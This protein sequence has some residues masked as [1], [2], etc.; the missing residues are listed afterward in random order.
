VSSISQAFTHL[1]LILL[2][3][4][5]RAAVDDPV[6]MRFNNDSGSNYDSQFL[7]SFGSSTNAAH[8]N[9]GTVFQ[10]AGYTTG[11]TGAANK[12]GIIE[13]VIPYYTQTTFHKT[14][15]GSGGAVLNSTVD[16][17]RTI[18]TAGVWRSTA[19]INRIALLP[20]TGTNF[21]TGSHLTIYGL[22]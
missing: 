4:S 1:K 12:A 17:L 2:C 5:D 13:I 7:Q 11:D 21:R 19:A 9:A 16:D 14:Y 15:S 20:F 8:Q 22:N 18:T 6:A 10:Y 3:R